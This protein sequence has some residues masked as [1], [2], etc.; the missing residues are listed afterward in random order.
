M[1]SILASWRA[2]ATVRNTATFVPRTF[3]DPTRSYATRPPAARITLGNLAPAPGSTKQRKRLGRGQGSGRGGTSTKGHKGQNA[4]SGGPRPGFEGGQTPLTRRFPKRGFHNPGSREYAPLN[5]ERLQFWIDQGRVEVHEDRAITAT[6]LV[7]S[8]VVH[9]MHDGV[10]LLGDGAE[11]FHTAINIIVSRASQSAIKAIEG[12]GGTVVCRHYNTLGL[13]D[14][15]KGDMKHKLAA[16]MREKDILY[17]SN[18]RRN[19]GY[20]AIPPEIR[21]RTAFSGSHLDVP[22]HLRVAPKEQKPQ[23]VDPEAV[24]DAAQAAPPPPAKELES[25]PAP[26]S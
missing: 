8:R 16:P 20:L 10:K 1:N 17:Y 6:E 12:A 18:W 15:K 19:R 4:R 2:L 26:Y 23:P 24:M 25:Q 9:Q 11:Y 14:L 5:L 7:K 3:L 13:L 21:A 22:E